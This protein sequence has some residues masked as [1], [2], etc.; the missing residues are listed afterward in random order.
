MDQTV[1]GE[2]DIV[3][4]AEPPYDSSGVVTLARSRFDKT[5]K[6]PLSGS[7]QVE[8]LGAVATT[9]GSM[10][11]VALERVVGELD[12]KRGGFVL[13]HSAAM[14]RGEKSQTITVVPDSADGEL[15]G[16]SGRMEIDIVD[17][18]HFYAFHYSLPGQAQSR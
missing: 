10:A 8:M 5:Y 15:T 2:F 16:L 12:G 14:T 7:G 17:G 4:H 1:R 3:R 18:K 11:Y 13:Q 6:G 9:P